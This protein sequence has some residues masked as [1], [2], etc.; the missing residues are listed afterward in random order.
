MSLSLTILAILVLLVGSAVFS[1]SEMAFSSANRMRLSS[2]AEEGSR[3][4]KTALAVMDRYED[5]LSAILI[6]NNLCNIGADSLATVLVITVLGSRYRPISAVLTTAVMT[7]IVIFLC[8]SAPKIT[9]KKN[10][11]RYSMALA[12]FIRGLMLL[13]SPVIWLVKG[14]IWL[15]TLP[16]P[17]EKR[18]EDPE[19]AAAE[20]QSIIETAEDEDV[21]DEDRSELLLSA[22]DFSQIPV[23]DVMTARVDVQ[24]LDADE[25]WEDV[26]L[27]GEEEPY[28]RLPVYEESIDNIIGVLHLNRFFRALL[29]DPGTDIRSCLMK[30]LYIYK[31]VKLPDV[32]D[33]FRRSQQ[34]LAVVTDE[35]GATLGI[36]TLEDVLEQIVG[37]IWDESDEVE[38]DVVARPDGAFEVD[39]D[40]PLSEFAELLGTEEE[41]LSAD[42]ATVGGWTIEKF[43][44]FPKA[45]DSFTADGVRIR[46]L[47]MDEDGLRV[48]KILAEKET[49]T[50]TQ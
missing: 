47:A 29:E 32:L 10:A 2:A 25:P 18:E 46:V 39:G 5:A 49:N 22:L 21:I 31:T 9:A 37:E 26:L 13:L 34:H 14:L 24:A 19:E 44:A 16:F 28:S 43:G 33:Q 50:N 3:P 40:L 7:L 23:M 12:G 30:P 41:E 6:G 4:A 8:E 45:G 42:S 35:Y 17:G 15:L 20:L 38:E 48:E 1:A 11:N 27:T 36:V